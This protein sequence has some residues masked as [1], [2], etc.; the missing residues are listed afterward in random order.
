MS[1]E[2]FTFFVT[3]VEAFYLIPHGK[4]YI[5][6]IYYQ[7]LIVLEELGKVKEHKN[8][9]QHKLTN[10]WENLSLAYYNALD[11]VNGWMSLQHQKCN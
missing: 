3:D 7:E 5:N 10:K 11:T 4:M 6:R 8:N 9:V 1:V 2:L